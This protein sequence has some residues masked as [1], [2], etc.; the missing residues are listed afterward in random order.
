VDAA[1]RRPGDD[2]ADGLGRIRVRGRG[3]RAAGRADQGRQASQYRY[4][5]AP[6]S[7]L[8]QISCGSSEDHS[9]RRRTLE[10]SRQ[11]AA[12]AW[13]KSPNGPR[14]ANSAPFASRFKGP[15]TAQF[16]SLK[17][18]CILVLSERL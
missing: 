4:V 16:A 12:R 5:A 8:L 13:V 6:H 11:P 2:H 17:Y 14:E 7:Y 10:G 18:A 15:D 9:V 1:A 3:R